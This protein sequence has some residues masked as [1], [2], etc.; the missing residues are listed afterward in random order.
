MH[1]SICKLQSSSPSPTAHPAWRAAL[2][3]L[4]NKGGPPFLIGYNVGLD[5]GAVTQLCTQDKNTYVCTS[6]DADGGVLTTF[7]TY[8]SW[9]CAEK[10][11]KSV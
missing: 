6:H 1:H 8:T 7:G 5:E 3:P 2:K 9:E 4:K 10:K 11:G